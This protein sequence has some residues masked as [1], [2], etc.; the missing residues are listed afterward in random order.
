M[1]FGWTVILNVQE[2]RVNRVCLYNSASDDLCWRILK[3]F[4]VLVRDTVMTKSNVVL[5]YIM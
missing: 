1:A 2:Q 4:I 5:I 3:Y